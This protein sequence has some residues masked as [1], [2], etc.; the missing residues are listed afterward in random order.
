MIPGGP[1][2]RRGPS[3]RGG[4]SRC[5]DDHDRR[6]G[7]HA[8]RSRSDLQ[9]LE[10]GHGHGLL[11]SERMIGVTRRL[12]NDRGA[13]IVIVAAW[14]TSAI[15]LVTFV[16]DVGHWYEHKRHLQVQ[17]DAAAFGGG[18]MFAG[19]FNGGGGDSSILTEA[20]KYAGATG[21]WQ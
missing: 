3:L 8:A 9:R 15:A 14:M 5:R 10:H 21:S 7:C 20:S 2:G 18:G 17:V 11:P 12:S 1:H 16:I 19:C 13:V 4:L 6:Q